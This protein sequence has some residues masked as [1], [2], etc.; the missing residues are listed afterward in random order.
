[1]VQIWEKGVVFIKSLNDYI[2]IMQPK[3]NCRKWHNYASNL[4][5]KEKMKMCNK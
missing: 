2:S 5:Q 4:L 1:L 3:E